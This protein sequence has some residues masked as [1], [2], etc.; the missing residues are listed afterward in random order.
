VDGLVFHAYFGGHAG[1]KP[2]QKELVGL[3]GYGGLPIE[4]VADQPVW[5]GGC[6]SRAGPSW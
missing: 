4:V 2:W 1:E 3:T 6:C 5:V